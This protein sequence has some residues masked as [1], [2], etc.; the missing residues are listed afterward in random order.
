MESRIRGGVGVGVGLG[1]TTV[2]YRF[3]L[4]GKCMGGWWVKGSY[5]HHMTHGQWTL[6]CFSFCAAYILR[7]SVPGGGGGGLTFKPSGWT[8]LFCGEGLLH[9]LFSEWEMKSGD[10]V[11]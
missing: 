8:V 9:R 2:L 10:T 6:R 1:S 3:G 11:S 5:L 4:D 7:D